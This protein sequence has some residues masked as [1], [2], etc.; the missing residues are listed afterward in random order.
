MIL[1]CNNLYIRYNAI[2]QY[3]SALRAIT[4]SYVSILRSYDLEGDLVYF[5]SF[6]VVDGVGCCNGGCVYSGSIRSNQVVPSIVALRSDV[7]SVLAEL[8]WYWLINKTF[9]LH[10]LYCLGGMCVACLIG[11]KNVPVKVLAK[12]NW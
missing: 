5:F 2:D 11:S 3:R 4:L 9:A 6:V 7:F 8:L 1:K 10:H 12:L